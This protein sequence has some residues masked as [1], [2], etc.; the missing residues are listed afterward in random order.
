M[1]PL[2][3]ALL[4]AS[5]ATAESAPDAAGSPAGIAP[6][7][8]Q[9]G[10]GVAL[11]A[12]GCFWC[13]ESA[14]DPL[15]GVISAVSGFAGGS[16]ERPAYKD[17]ARGKTGHTEVVRVVF[18]P[19][20]LSYAQVLEVF[21]LN[22]DPF[23]PDGQFCDQGS[24]YRPAIFPMDDE[25]KRIALAQKGQKA[26]QLGKAILTHI[27][28]PAIFWEAEGYHQDFWKTNASHYE[29]YRAGCGRDKRLYQVWGQVPKQ[30]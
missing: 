26:E 8:T 29:R 27:E 19:A 6:A 7:P 30:H 12:G 13:L 10:H 25:Q 15:D 16:E 28:P 17:V 24:Q 22:H 9:D 1:R 5:C 2:L 18:D 23:D 20:K 3:L 21:W 4:L 11:L 14:Y